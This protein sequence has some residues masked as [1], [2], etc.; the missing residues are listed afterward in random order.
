MGNYQMINGRKQSKDGFICSSATPEK[1]YQRCVAVKITADAVMVRDTKDKNDT[2][3]T[4]NH[5]EWN[6]FLDGVR[7]NEF[8]V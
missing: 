1:Y 3:L 7:K 2:T 4:F 5:N 6:A 8:N